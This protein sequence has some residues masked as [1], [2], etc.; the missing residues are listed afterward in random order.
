MNDKI[1]CEYQNLLINFLNSKYKTALIS[2][3]LYLHKTNI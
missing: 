2:A 1:M 3:V